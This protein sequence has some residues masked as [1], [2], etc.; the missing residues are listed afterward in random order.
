MM[1]ALKLRCGS[2]DLKVRISFDPPR[3]G[4]ITSEDILWSTHV[5][6]HQRSGEFYLE[7]SL[8][9]GVLPHIRCDIQGR[10][11]WKVLSSHPYMRRIKGQKFKS[12]FFLWL[13]CSIRQQANVSSFIWTEIDKK[14]NGRSR[15]RDLCPK[16]RGCYSSEC[17]LLYIYKSQ[18][19]SA[20]PR[21]LTLLFKKRHLPNINSLTSY[22]PLPPF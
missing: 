14:T 11:H 7:S 1:W 12:V 2:M 8:S 19:S 22:L 17:A 3:G 10:P 16:P 9:G 13:L 5:V 4:S 6:S 20:N 21:F 15:R 18:T